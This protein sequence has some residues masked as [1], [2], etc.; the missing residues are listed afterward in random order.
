MQ[1]YI[2]DRYNFA[3]THMLM[4]SDY[5]I[6]IDSIY[7]DN[8]SI[9]VVGE[10]SGIEGD[11]ICVQGWV[12]IVDSVTPERGVTQI[13]AKNILNA[14]SRPLLPEIGSSIEGFIAETL[15]NE[16]VGISDAMY[17]MPYISISAS[18]ETAFI[19]P[20]LE[21]G[22]WTLKSYIAKARRLKKVFVTWSVDGDTLVCSI[23]AKNVPVRTVDF[24]DSANRL[25]SESYSRYT[26]GKITAVDTADNST[27]EYY[28]HSDGSYSTEDSDR[29]PGEWIVIA[30]DAENMENAVAEEFARSSF[31]HMIEFGSSRKYDFYDSLRVRINGR[32]LQSYISTVRISNTAGQLYRSGEL[33]VTL[34]DKMKGMI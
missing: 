3:T 15:A 12:G 27:I 16:Y 34:T 22:F 31:S 23:S 32:V 25:L 21:D 9:T 2:K 7:D 17:A 24:S 14:F 10:I 28:A 29:V 4:V 20:D 1:C 6:V 11:F 26:V 13:T 8:S 18:G 33:R 30:T 19:T 5:D